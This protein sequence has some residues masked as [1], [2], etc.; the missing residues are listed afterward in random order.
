MSHLGRIIGGAAALV[1]SSAD[2]DAT[3]TT[4]GLRAQTTFNLGGANLT[5]KTTLGWRHAFG[6]VTPPAN[7]RFA[8]GGNG[9][10]IAGVPLARNAAVIEAGLDYAIS[11]SATLGI[12]YG[13]QAATARLF[14]QPATLKESSCAPAN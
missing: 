5:A 3:F 14:R 6:D 2:T 9:F 13:G 8:G 10:G 11:P 4:L 1:G 12:A 7:L